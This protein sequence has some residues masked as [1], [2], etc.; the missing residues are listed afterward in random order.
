MRKVMYLLE[1][2]IDLPGGAQI[3]TQ[4]LCQGLRKAKAGIDPVVVCPSLLEKSKEDY[5]YSVITYK[6]YENRENRKIVRVMNLVLRIFAYRKLIS[7]EKPD[8]IHIQMPESAITYGILKTVGLFP[9]IKYVFTDRGLYYGY[10]KHS[11][12]LL[13]HSL[14]YGDQILCTTKLNKDLWLKN[15]GFSN[16]A[17]ISNTISD[18]FEEYREEKRREVRKEQGYGEK[19]FVLGFAGRVCE[20]KNWPLVQKICRALVER[21]I[22]YKVDLVMAVFE[23]GDEKVVKEVRKGIEGCIGKE[24][25]CYRQ[26]LSQSEMAD[27]YYG[28]DVFLMTSKFESFGKAAVE[29]MSRK[30]ALISTRAGGLAEVIGKEENLFEEENIEKCV[31]YIEEVERNRVKLKEEKEFFYERFLKNYS[32]KKCLEEHILLYEKLLRKG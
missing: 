27:Y 18:D 26:D 13:C 29:A 17:L 1:Y 3:S 20:E 25:L 8:I 14:K 5:L 28:V 24:N 22:H 16:I 12:A 4:S 30:C 10:R 6:A 23:Q 7:K 32:P 19:D 11:M 2:P 31:D 9:K 15:T 21:N